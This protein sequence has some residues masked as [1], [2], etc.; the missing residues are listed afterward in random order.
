MHS[1]KRDLIREHVHVYDLLKNSD[2]RGD[3]IQMMHAPANTVDAFAG[4]LNSLQ[5]L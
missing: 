4:F 3:F 1:I 5:L 2:E